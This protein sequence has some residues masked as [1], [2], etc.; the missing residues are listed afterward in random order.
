MSRSRYRS[1]VC[2]YTRT[3]QQITVSYTAAEARDLARWLVVK[4]TARVLPY[5]TVPEPWLRALLRD[6]QS[7]QA[8]AGAL[9]TRH[10]DLLES[11]VYFETFRRLRRPHGRAVA[12]AVALIDEHARCVR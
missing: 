9:G 2:P 3:N 4:R 8:L 10:V 7:T 1:S 11:A 6:N 12:V 5:A